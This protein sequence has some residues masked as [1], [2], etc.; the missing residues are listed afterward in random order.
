MATVNLY[1]ETEIVLRGW[2]IDWSKDLSEESLAATSSRGGVVD[3]NVVV[4]STD[5]LLN[6]R[7]LEYL[8]IHLHMV[9]SFH[10]VTLWE[11]HT[12]THRTNVCVFQ[13]APFHYPLY[14]DDTCPLGV[15]SWALWSSSALWTTWR[16]LVSHYFQ[17]RQINK[18]SWPL[19]S[20]GTVST[21][22]CKNRIW[23]ADPSYHSTWVWYTCDCFTFDT[24][25]IHKLK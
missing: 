17:R 23:M 10:Q 19:I 14:T 15:Y 24:I 18:T 20:P 3:V 16:S 7:L 2:F 8:S 21:S 6:K 13:E 25:F 11:T 22:L 4:L 5:R 1:M 9:L 12:H